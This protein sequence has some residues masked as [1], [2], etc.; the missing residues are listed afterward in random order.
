MPPYPSTGKVVDLR[1]WTTFAWA[2]WRGADI[3]PPAAPLCAP[4]LRNLGL[5]PLLY[6]AL[7]D[8]DDGRADQFRADH[9][10]AAT[11][12]L[13][14]LTHTGRLRDRLEAAGIP[15]VLLKGAA[16]LLRFAPDDLGIRPMSDLDWLVPAEQYSAAAALLQREQFRQAHPDLARSSR[17]APAQAFVND[18]GAM[19]V[20]IDLHRAIAP[21]PLDRGLAARTLRQRELHGGWYVPSAPDALAIAAV[22]RARHGFV[23]SCLDLLD[24][25]LLM[26]AIVDEAWPECLEQLREV[27][28]VHATYA[29]F[30]QALHVFGGEQPRDQAR[31]AALRSS[32]R[33]SQCE[34]LERLAPLD[35]AFVPRLDRERPL[36]R[37]FV[38]Q[39]LVSGSWWRSVAAAAV[40]LPVRLVEEWDTAGVDAKD[41]AAA[42]AA[43]P[44]AR[45]ARIWHHAVRGKRRLS[46]THS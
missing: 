14:R 11:A 36:I 42:P 23:W 16:I 27:H 31:L 4:L 25:R 15:V 12:S 41:R 26:D 3:A 30:R 22:H 29:T 2:R 35:G 46:D 28:A 21:W 13:L 38:V 18:G 40:Y 32:L 34:A 17:L 44:L 20:E 33:L 45:V 24:V 43:R 1:A 5:A 6:R 37:S 8:A 7:D 10:Y 9:R 39:P 19:G